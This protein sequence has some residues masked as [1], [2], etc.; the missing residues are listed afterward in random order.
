MKIEPCP[1]NPH[2]GLNGLSDSAKQAV[3][4]FARG[5]TERRVPLFECRVLDLPNLQADLMDYLWRMRRLYPGQV[6]SVKEMSCWLLRNEQ[7]IKPVEYYLRDLEKRGYLKV[8]NKNDRAFK[9]EILR[10]EHESA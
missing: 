8:T 9:I 1:L 5:N 2:A 7:F 6:P 4:D 10:G 3:Y